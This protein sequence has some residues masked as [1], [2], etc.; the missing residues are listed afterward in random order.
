MAR[1]MEADRQMWEE[2]KTYVVLMLMPSASWVG[3]ALSP[4]LSPAPPSQAPPQKLCWPQS[5]LALVNLGLFHRHFPPPARV[6]FCFS[7]S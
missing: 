5:H 3:P 1:G 6:S 2:R 4:H 7:D